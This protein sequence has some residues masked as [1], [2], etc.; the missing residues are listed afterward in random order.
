MKLPKTIRLNY[1]YINRVPLVCL[2]VLFFLIFF[3]ANLT[4]FLI[5]FLTL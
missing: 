5:N 4:L 1:W 2:T 3:C